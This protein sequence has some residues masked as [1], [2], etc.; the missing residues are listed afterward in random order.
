MSKKLTRAESMREEMTRDPIFIL[1][2]KQHFFNRHTA[3]AHN[4]H[5]DDEGE[6]IWPNGKLASMKT[7]ED[8]EVAIPYWATPG[9][10]FYSRAEAEKHAEDR[11]YDWGKKDVNWRVYCTCAEGELAQALDDHEKSLR[12]VDKVLYNLKMLEHGSTNFDKP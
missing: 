2:R 12:A 9:N 7:L 5:Q 3:E 8:I 10:V 1:Q 4:L 11:H 6:Y